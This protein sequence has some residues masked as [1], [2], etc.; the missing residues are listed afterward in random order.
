MNRR[1][2]RNETSEREMSAKWARNADQ[3]IV[4]AMKDKRET[5]GLDEV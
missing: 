4:R 1:K 3:K 2:V 5:K